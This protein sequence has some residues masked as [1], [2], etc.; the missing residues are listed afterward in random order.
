MTVE[1]GTAI[2]TVMEGAELPVGTRTSV[3]E[4]HFLYLLA[5]VR[6]AGITL[7]NI[8]A[9]PSDCTT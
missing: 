8:H 4:M 2:I 7:T 9:D 3:L 6:Q 1:G 5:W